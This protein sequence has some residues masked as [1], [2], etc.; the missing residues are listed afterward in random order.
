L[1]PR[2][3]VELIMTIGFYL[4]AARITETTRTDLDPPAGTRVIDQIRRAR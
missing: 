4:T 1:S 3:I 2:E